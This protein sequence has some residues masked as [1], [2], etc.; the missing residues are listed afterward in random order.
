MSSHIFTDLSRSFC[1]TSALTSAISSH[2]SYTTGI[3]EQLYSKL[4]NSV[5]SECI[6]APKLAPQSSAAHKREKNEFASPE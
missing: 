2:L 4:C 1:W 3:D 5:V 6:Q